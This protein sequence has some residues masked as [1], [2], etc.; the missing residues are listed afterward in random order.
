M[1]TVLELTLATSDKRAGRVW[2]GQAFAQVAELERLFSRYDPES[3]LSRLNAA[4]GEGM[5]EV[6][7]RLEELLALSLDYGSLTQGCFDVTVLPLVDLWMQAVERQRVP[8]PDELL[9][10]RAQVG[11]AVLRLAGDGRVELASKGARVDLGAIAKGYALDRLAAELHG[12][13]RG[14]AVALLNFGESSVRALGAPPGESGW[15]LLLRTPGGGFA[16]V[17][18]LRDRAFSVSSSLGQWTLIG[19]QRYGHVID[20]RSGQPVT[21]ALQ[22]AVIAPTGAFAE[23]LS[24]A[25][26]VLGEV[27]GIAL[28]E[29]ISGAEAMLVDEQ[30]A[31]T[32]SAGWQSASSFESIAATR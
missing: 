16:G 14:G 13:N 8:S 24:T 18:T 6:D 2:I 9:Q 23:A 31:V 10:V 27:E 17:V 4:A 3:E 21:R 19:D 7:R 20:P 28:I 25:L 29:S 1:G 32:S 15:R 5:Q 22:A 12:P 26:V 30:G 11:S